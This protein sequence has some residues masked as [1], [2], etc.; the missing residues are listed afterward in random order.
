MNI[1]ITFKWTFNWTTRCFIMKVKKFELITRARIQAVIWERCTFSN[2]ILTF[3]NCASQNSKEFHVFFQFG[4]NFDAQIMKIFKIH[5]K[6][7]I[8]QTSVLF[9]KYLCNKSSDLYEIFNFSL[10]DSNWPPKNFSWRSMHKCAR[11]S[12]KCPHLR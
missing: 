2:G 12:R 4:G 6:L 5:W 7:R 11:M 3:W 9:C 10:Q 8:K 1:H